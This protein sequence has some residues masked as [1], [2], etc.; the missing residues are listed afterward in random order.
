MEGKAIVEKSFGRR[1]SQGFTQLVDGGTPC[2]GSWV[3]PN[4]SSFIA[5]L[6]WFYLSQQG[7]CRQYSISLMVLGLA[8]SMC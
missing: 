4:F 1:M 8:Y 2:Y 3:H 7:G 6:D 5:G